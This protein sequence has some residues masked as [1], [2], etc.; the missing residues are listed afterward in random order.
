M[1]DKKHSLIQSEESL[2]AQKAKLSQENQ[3]KDRLFAAQAQAHKRQLAAERQQ[4]DQQ[5]QVK[6]ALLLFGPL[7]P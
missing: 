2:L 1:T 5:M 4:H 7:N 6:L 3:E